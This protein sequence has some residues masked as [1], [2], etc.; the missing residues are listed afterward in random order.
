V[1]RVFQWLALWIGA[2]IT[3]IG[4]LYFGLTAMSDVPSWVV[5]LSLVLGVVLT[6]T[7]V[8]G[9]AWE[10]VSALRGPTSARRPITVSV[11]RDLLPDHGPVPPAALEAEPRA[12]SCRR[13]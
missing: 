2:A 13:P 10:A 3:G 9:M 8:L 4:A 11:P 12:N 6:A 1:G 7:S 5:G